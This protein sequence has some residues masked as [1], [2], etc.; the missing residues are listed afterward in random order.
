MWWEKNED[1]DQTIISNIA[2]STS[3]KNSQLED[4]YIAD[5]L[6]LANWQM[7]TT[8]KNIPANF[9]VVSN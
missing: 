7:M 6:S 2:L 8:L 9:P 5:R 1:C 3:V 4:I